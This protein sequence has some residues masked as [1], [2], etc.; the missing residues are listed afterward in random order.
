MVFIRGGGYGTVSTTILTDG[1]HA[2]PR[3]YFATG[4]EMEQAS[5]RWHASVRKGG[6]DWQS[7][8]QLQHLPE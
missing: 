1:K 3:Y 8:Y 7:P 5:A 6:S 4:D 2:P